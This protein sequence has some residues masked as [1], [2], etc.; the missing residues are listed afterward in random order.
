AMCAGERLNLLFRRRRMRLHEF[1]MACVRL[2]RVDVESLLTDGN[3]HTPPE[4]VAIV[5]DDLLERPFVDRRLLV[6]PAGAFFSFIGNHG[7]AAEFDAFNRP[8]RFM[9]PLNDRYA[10]EPRFLKG[11]KKFVFTQRSGDATAP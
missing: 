4:N 11:L 10:V 6:V 5:I 3:P 1:K 9:L 2:S 7:H 8:P